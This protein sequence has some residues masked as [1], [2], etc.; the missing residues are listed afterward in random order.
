MI[1]FELLG[2]IA[3]FCALIFLITNFLDKRARRRV[4][5]LGAVAALAFLFNAG[6]MIYNLVYTGANDAFDYFIALYCKMQYIMRHLL[7]HKI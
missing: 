6:A 3:V 2:I 1:V 5:A 7:K 4:V